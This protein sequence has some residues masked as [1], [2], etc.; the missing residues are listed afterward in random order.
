MSGITPQVADWGRAEDAT[1]SP[2]DR[3]SQTSFDPVPAALHAAAAE[4]RL[5]KAIDAEVI[6]RLLLAH[7]HRGAGAAAASSSAQARM[8]EA[9]LSLLL[10]EGVQAAVARLE[11][12]HENGASTE[13]IYLD[14]LAPAARRLGQRWEADECDFSLVTTA[15]LQLQQ[16][17]RRLAPQFASEAPA[18]LPSHRIVLASAPGEQHTFGISMLVEFF[19][20][21]G[22]DVFDEP[23][24]SV[25]TLTDLVRGHWVG[26]VGLSLSAETGLPALS[27]AIRAVRHHS[28]NPAVGIMVGGAAFAGRPERVARVGADVCAVDARQAVDLARDLLGLLAQA[29]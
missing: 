6:P 3:A 18:R 22:W 11:S 27:S 16:V 19:R 24:E 7:R 25:A 23:L 20:R 5:A 15:V 1:G 13:S 10:T 12:L 14:I 8:V 29:R 2:P 17:M 28:R 4:K 26:V 9:L 21:D